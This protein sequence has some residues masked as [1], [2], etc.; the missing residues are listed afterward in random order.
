MK[1]VEW[2]GFVDN[3]GYSVSRFRRMEPPEVREKSESS[4]RMLET[5]WVGLRTVTGSGSGIKAK[6]SHI[7]E[8]QEASAGICLGYF[9]NQGELLNAFICMSLILCLIKHTKKNTYV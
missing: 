5:L 4:I 2:L 1:H 8:G 7:S 3:G 6:F 9:R